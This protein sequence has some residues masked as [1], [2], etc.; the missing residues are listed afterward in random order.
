MWA[1]IMHVKMKYPLFKTYVFPLIVVLLASIVLVSI[2]GWEK[3]LV[4][5][6]VGLFVWLFSS[7]FH[8]IVDKQGINEEIQ[9]L[10]KPAKK[11]LLAFM[12]FGLIATTILIT[13]LAMR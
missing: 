1:H 11:V 8:F 3:G 2:I 7:L 9:R 12:I 6:L 5:S 10:S 13:I 4:P